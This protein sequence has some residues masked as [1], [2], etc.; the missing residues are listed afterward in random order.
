MRF[1]LV[2]GGVP[3]LFMARVCCVLNFRSQFCN[4]S[5]SSWHV[6]A[7]SIL[8]PTIL[9]CAPC[10][11]LF[12]FHSLAKFQL[13]WDFQCCSDYEFCADVQKIDFIEPGIC[14]FFKFLVSSSF[15]VSNKFQVSIFQISLKVENEI[16]LNF[17][18]F[19]NLSVHKN[20][21]KQQEVENGRKLEKRKME[22]D[23]NC[24]FPWRCLCSQSLSSSLV[25]FLSCFERLSLLE[26]PV[27]IL[28]L[29]SLCLLSSR[30]CLAFVSFRRWFAQP[31]WIFSG[32]STSC[33]R[34]S[35][36][37]LALLALNKENF[38]GVDY[39]F[40][41]FL[42]KVNMIAC[43]ERGDVECRLLHSKTLFPSQFLLTRFNEFLAAWSPKTNLSLLD[44][45]GFFQDHICLGLDLPVGRLTRRAGD[46]S[47]QKSNNS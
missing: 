28:R 10:P 12:N 19:W 23:R 9:C 11:W 38:A 39:S 17:Y 31:L 18:F 33:R 37:P 2:V 40:N 34:A 27:I 1:F 22:G 36:R 29:F 14:E 32:S 8:V 42:C 45:I 16:F 20:S 4:D 43:G 21:E 7:V 24:A 15:L 13:F 46:S 47:Y 25:S 6:G 5:H 26:L 35:R 44:T 3:L 41:F 30:W